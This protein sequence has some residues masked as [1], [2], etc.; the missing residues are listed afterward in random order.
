MCNYTYDDSR[1]TFEQLFRRQWTLLYLASRCNNFVV[2]NPAKCHFMTVAN[3]SKKGNAIVNFIAE[4]AII[5]YK[6]LKKII[7]FGI[8]NYIL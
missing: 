2:L 6:N 4:K 5:K 3:N 8:N 1:Y 7:G